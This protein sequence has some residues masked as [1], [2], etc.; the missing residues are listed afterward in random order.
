M[1][2]EE[3]TTDAKLMAQ[4]QEAANATRSK[5][6]YEE[7]LAKLFPGGIR[8]RTSTVQGA[9]TQGVEDI[10]GALGFETA[11]NIGE[12]I[13]A[14]GSAIG[15]VAAQFDE[16]TDPDTGAIRRSN[17]VIVDPTAD[18]STG[19]V[20]APNSD[21]E[22]S[23]KWLNEAADWSEDK[24]NKWR[25]RLVK[26]GYDVSTKGPFDQS[27]RSNLDLYFR[28]KYFYGKV[29]PIDSSQGGRIRPVDVMDPV[30][31][32]QD[33]RAAYQT[34]FGD[35]PSDAELEVWE[36]SYRR[37]LGRMLHRSVKPESVAL[38]AKERFATRF[39]DDPGVQKFNELEEE[40]TEMADWFTTLLGS[41]G[42]L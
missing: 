39:T 23:F 9:V 27:L 1:G 22:G 34:V 31:I 10:S 37:T 2:V 16:Y 8:P 32:R 12:G 38:R 3:F 40:D 36:D 18:P 14:V 30:E 25:E 20:Y 11:T 5:S 35:D 21:V 19:V 42:S 4:I 24:V 15:S 41:L 28:N 26:L 17:G 6:L 33:V 7:V 29:M 13:E